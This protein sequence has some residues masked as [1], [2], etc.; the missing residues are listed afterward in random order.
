MY[1]QKDWANDPTLE[2]T[3]I[4]SKSTSPVT[5]YQHSYIDEQ[6]G[7]TVYMGW[8][9][10]PAGGLSG[11]LDDVDLTLDDL[12]SANYQIHYA[13]EKHEDVAFDGGEAYEFPV[14]YFEFKAGAQW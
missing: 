7:E 10:I 2:I 8:N 6:D 5:T 3:Q 14:I 13:I 1:V 12:V 11:W 4:I 9:F